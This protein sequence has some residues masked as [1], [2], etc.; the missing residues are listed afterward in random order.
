MTQD[1]LYDIWRPADSPWSVWVKPVLFAFVRAKNL[2]RQGFPRMSW[3]VPRDEGTAVLIDLPG[4]EGVAAGIALSRAGYR[5]IPIYNASPFVTHDPPV[6]PVDA[7]AVVD[8]IPILHALCASANDLA[9]ASLPPAA[10]P[11]FL[12]DAN[13]EG[14]A[15]PDPGWFDNR[16]FVTPK[17]F[18]SADFFRQHG[19]NRL[20]LIQKYLKIPSDLLQVLLRL[21]AGGLT[22][23]RQIP[24]QA[25]DPQPFPVKRPA[26]VTQAWGKLHRAF[27]YRRDAF[28]TFGARVPPSSS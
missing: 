6:E 26:L 14:F 24:W 27:G 19:L 2:K 21:Q 28:G 18:P 12:L 16:S 4:E 7:V 15:G 5:P 20:V 9:A 13:L 11:A 23:A 3:H 1:E 22:I 17:D 25:W 10:P 8:V